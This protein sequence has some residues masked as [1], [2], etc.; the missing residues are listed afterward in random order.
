MDFRPS[1]DFHAHVDV[2]E[3]TIDGVSYV[4]PSVGYAWRF[5]PRW[6]LAGSFSYSINTFFPRAVLRYKVTDGLYVYGGLVTDGGIFHV[7]QARGIPILSYSELFY[8]QQA[9]KVGIDWNVSK[10]WDIGVSLGY[11]L[12]QQFGYHR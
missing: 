6:Q 10:G 7:H 3:I 1:D 12:K 2:T 11:S 5:A 9:L 4:G 8:Y